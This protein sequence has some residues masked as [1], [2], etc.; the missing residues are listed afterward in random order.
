MLFFFIFLFF[1]S[2]EY[3]AGAEFVKEVQ[4]EEV[5][6]LFYHFCAMFFFF[7]PSMLYSSLLQDLLVL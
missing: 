2:F 1:C 4:F 5:E 6:G 7:F 3:H